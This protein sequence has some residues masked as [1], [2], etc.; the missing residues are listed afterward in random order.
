MNQD[1][2]VYVK[3]YIRLNSKYLFCGNLKVKTPFKRQ[4]ILGLGLQLFY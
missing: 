3:R 1:C 2:F 4:V